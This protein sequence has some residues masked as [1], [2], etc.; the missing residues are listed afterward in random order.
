M[1]RSLRIVSVT[2]GLAA[3]GAVAGVAIAFVGHMAIMLAAG[4]RVASRAQ[5]L[6]AGLAP[7]LLAFLLPR[8]ALLG[9]LVGPPVA[10]GLLRR[11]PI[12]RAALVTAVGALVGGVSGD[13]LLSALFWGRP[14][15]IR[16]GWLWCAGRRR[17]GGAGAPAR[18]RA[19]EPVQHRIGRA[20]G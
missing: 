8:G 12:G 17:A 16:F 7:M 9:A 18:V 5:V 14:S 15:P 1:R 4:L 20:G 11:V 19:R 2:A 10:W 3:L 6:E 13:L